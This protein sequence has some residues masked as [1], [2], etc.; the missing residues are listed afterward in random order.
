MIDPRTLHPLPVLIALLS[1]IVLPS[2][3]YWRT[4]I[5]LPKRPKALM[6]IL[7]PIVT[8]SNTLEVDP[9]LI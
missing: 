3:T 2:C 7:E 6:L 8:C 4:L 9:A 5:L 1:E